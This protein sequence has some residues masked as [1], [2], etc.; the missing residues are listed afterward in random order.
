[1]VV[2]FTLTIFLS[3]LLLFGVQPMAGKMLLPFLGGT[4]GVWNT[5]MMFFQ[6]VLLLGYL[7][8]HGI[9]RLRALP[10]LLLQ[11]GLL[12]VAVVALPLSM[13]RMDFSSEW[14]VHQPVLWLVA[15]LGLGVGLPFMALSTSSPLLQAWFARQDHPRAHD[16]YFLY[17]ASNAGSLLAL[18]AFPLLVE[19]LFGVREQATWWSGGFVVLAILMGVCGVMTLR[20]SPGY[21]G[22]TSAAHPADSDDDAPA[23]TSRQKGLWILYAFVPSSLMLGVTTYITTDVAAFPLLW[24]IPL[25]IFIASFIVV[26]SSIKLNL[27]LLGRVMSLLG[28]ALLIGWMMGATNP[29]WLLL[30]LHV[31]FFALVTLVLHGRLAASRPSAKYLTGFYLYMSIGGLLG[32][33]FNTLLAPLIFT[34]IWEYPLVLILACALRPQSAA[35]LADPDR[36]WKRAAPLVAT[37]LMLG[38][39]WLLKRSEVAHADVFSFVLLAVPAV[40]AY[41]QVERPARFGMGLLGIFVAA[42]LVSVEYDTVFKKRTFYGV[43]EILKS[44]TEYRM[45]HGGTFHGHA[46][47]D[48]KGCTPQ[49]YYDLRGPMGSL[50]EIYREHVTPRRLA[51][52]GLG[53][54]SHACYAEP[55]DTLT[56][57]ELD[58]VVVEAAKGF[59]NVGRSPAAEVDYVAGDARIQLQEREYSEPYGMLIIDAFSS[60][61]IPIHLLTVEAMELYLSRIERDGMIAVHISNRYFDLIPV[62]E[63]LAEAHDLEFRVV[64]DV[65]LS[66]QE[67]AEGRVASTWGVLTRDAEKAR[68]LEALD[69]RWQTYDGPAVT[70]TDN[71]AAVNG[72]WIF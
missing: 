20:A 5:C 19:P 13:N 66:D 61:A 59:G 34:N 44:D 29:A 4:P 27:P 6:A 24:V 7:W 60:D 23:P 9:A 57:Y 63:G 11:L 10:Q 12:G 35:D 52:I 48:D 49:N 21:Q 15:A 71:H 36:P 42:S 25:A 28:T 16:P 58:P 43:V 22:K 3:A 39:V 68:A 31:V 41:S 67:I 46:L 64:D 1:M 65:H 55:E 62:L 40:I 14:L 51:V 72:L 53:L 18:L 2:V 56:F 17:A 69:P 38:S 33:V 8:A 54:G 50:F 30:P 32:G 37:L 26:F 45:I 70:W 47:I